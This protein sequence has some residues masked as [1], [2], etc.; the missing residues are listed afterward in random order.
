MTE[1]DGDPSGFDLAEGFTEE[2]AAAPADE[3]VY[4]V[5]LQLYEPT[6]VAA[7][8]ERAD[9]APDTARRHLARLA[10]IGVLDRSTEGPAT[11]RRND[12]YFEWRARDRLDQLSV[13]QLRERLAG[14]TEREQAFREQYAATAPDEVDALEHGGYDDVEEVWLDLSEWATVRRRIERLEAVRRQRA[15]DSGSGTGAV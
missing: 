3:R 6:R 13:D 4:R 1:S 10:D 14:L 7:V 12:S 9:C 11:Y 2:L 15:A 5:A 8:A